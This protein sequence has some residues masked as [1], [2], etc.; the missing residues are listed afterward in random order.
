MDPSAAP[1]SPIW[2]NMQRR[3]LGDGATS[4]SPGETSPGET[5]SGWGLLPLRPARVHSVENYFS[6]R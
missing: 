2:S 3:Y 4:T 1:R 6:L 5:V